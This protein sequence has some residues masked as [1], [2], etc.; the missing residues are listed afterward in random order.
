LTSRTT[1]SRA[2]RCGV[3]NTLVAS[4]AVVLTACGGGGDSENPPQEPTTYPKASTSGTFAEDF[5][6]VAHRGG[7]A[8]AP[9]N[10]LLAVENAARIG[11]DAIE[12]DVSLTDDGRLVIFHD[13]ELSRV[14]NCTGEIR[15]TPASVL[16]SCDA[17]YW[18][19]AGVPE[20]ASGGSRGTLRGLGIAVP[21]LKDVLDSPAITAA[22]APML[23][24]DAKVPAG[25]N[26][27]F[28]AQQLVNTLVTTIAEQPS[29][30][31]IVVMS[32]DGRVLTPLKAIAPQVDIALIHGQTTTRTCVQSAMDAVKRS[33]RFLVINFSLATTDGAAECVRTAQDGGV[34]VL[35]STVRSTNEM[36]TAA[37]TG[38]NG[39]ITPFPACLI[40]LTGRDAPESPY[41][42][43]VS[44]GT[45]L[46]KCG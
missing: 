13:F 27:A 17:A 9:E 1:L 42:D 8:Y 33:A 44:R 19:R 18:W 30:T 3:S 32:G 31:S 43:L 40:A 16:A 37:A 10:T 5:L 46:P 23:I 12:V 15:N 28:R 24:L 14:T 4:L 35:I 29:S 11:A 21:T 20:T 2:P 22:D 45:S 34:E 36:L 38:A 26:F 25:D 41:V 6:V 7:G 39:A